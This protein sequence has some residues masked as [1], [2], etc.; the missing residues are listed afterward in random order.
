[1][2]VVYSVV[3]CLVVAMMFAIREYRLGK[4]VLVEPEKKLFL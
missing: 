2:T 1:M 3:A 4:K